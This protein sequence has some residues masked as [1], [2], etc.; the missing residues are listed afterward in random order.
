MKIKSAHNK[1]TRLYKK[2]ESDDLTD[3]VVKT[4]TEL[5]DRPVVSNFI[6]EKV[7][8]F[9]IVLKTQCLTPS[10]NQEDKVDSCELGN[11][12]KGICNALMI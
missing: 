10:E 5:P 6:I 11:F 1:L 9:Q 7:R 12:E 8:S 4:W 2:L 3:S